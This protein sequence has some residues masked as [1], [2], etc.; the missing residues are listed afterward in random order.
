[1]MISIAYILILASISLFMYTIFSSLRFN[2]TGKV[3]EKRDYSSENIKQYEDSFMFIT[4]KEIKNRQQTYI[5]ISLL[6]SLPFILFGIIQFIIAVAFFAIIAIYL[7]LFE[8]NRKI[9]S[10]AR[11]FQRQVLEFIDTISNSLKAGLSF[12]QSLE[13]ASMQISNP[14]GQELN[15][16]LKQNSLGVNIDTALSK[17]SDRI[18]CDNF[19]LVIAAITTTRQLGGN[20]PQIF[21]TISETIRDRESMEGKINALTAQGKM[22]ALMMSSMPLILMIGVYLI[23]KKTIMPLFETTIGKMLLVLMII[24]NSLGYFFINKIVN[25]EV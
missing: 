10:R 20:L 9:K 18:K 15:F 13:N 14:M 23:D 7:P 12:N 21:T 22:Q 19:S 17:M 3:I 25:I 8:L 1:M 2:Q 5:M 6:L 16:V 11:E 4:K 24:L